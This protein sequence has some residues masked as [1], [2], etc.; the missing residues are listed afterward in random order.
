VTEELHFTSARRGLA[1]G[2]SGFCTV[3]RTAGLSNALQARLESLS[4]HELDSRTAQV[5]QAYTRVSLQGRSWCILSRVCDA[6]TDYTG[7]SNLYAHHLALT[8]AEAP[9]CGPAWLMR[10]AG[11][12]DTGW[13]GEP[14]IL[15]QGRALSVRDAPSGSCQTWQSVTGDAGWAGTLAAFTEANPDGV[16][17]LIHHPDTDVLA[18]F[19][20]ALRLLPASHRWLTGFST[21]PHPDRERQYAWRACLVGSPTARRAIGQPGALIID[22]SK[23]LPAAPD[24]PL[25]EQA[26]SGGAVR[27]APVSDKAARRAARPRKRGKQ[28]ALAA[29]PAL[30]LMPDDEAESQ[31]GAQRPAG[32]KVLP[33]KPLP[34]TDE[35]IMPAW[36]WLL[37]LIALIGCGVTLFMTLQGSSV[38]PPP[39]EKTADQTGKPK[40]DGSDS[41]GKVEGTQPQKRKGTPIK[42]VD[43]ETRVPQGSETK[44][45]ATKKPKKEPV[46]THV[47]PKP[48]Y[49]LDYVGIQLRE[50]REDRAGRKRIRAVS[51]L[52]VDRILQ[53]YP[54]SVAEGRILDQLNQEASL[55][56]F[57]EGSRS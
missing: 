54:L 47:L 7:R 1:P 3:A 37:G 55:P 46:T 43:K 23:T 10:Q 32:P 35:P 45:K 29:E 48:E 18:L 15:Q 13:A 44:R 27:P 31:W 4:A 33:R 42:T 51:V 5:N 8:V 50:L 49:I 25:V 6:G 40:R 19:D 36:V 21:L 11:V 12:L 9:A 14:R 26:R 39:P 17:W 57:H 22:C 38:P 24:G 34:R 56:G 53:V 41:N 28:A 52:R 20:E 30:E 16:A 2:V